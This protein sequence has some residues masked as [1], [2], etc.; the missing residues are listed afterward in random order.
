MEFGLSSKRE[1][2]LSRDAPHDVIGHF[3]PSR[4]TQ[5]NVV[6]RLTLIRSQHKLN[7]ILHVV[8][9]SIPALKKGWTCCS[10]S[11]PPV[12]PVTE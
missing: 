2:T 1:I 11:A 8:F 4:V 5:F 10:G 6:A 3:L 9:T 7:H 12:A